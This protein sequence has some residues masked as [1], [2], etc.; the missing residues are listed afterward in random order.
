MVVAFTTVV[1]E[2]AGKADAASVADV[3][4]STERRVKWNARIF[5][6]LNTCDL[7]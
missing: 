5:D 2:K 1:W 6:I 7:R 4:A 3:A